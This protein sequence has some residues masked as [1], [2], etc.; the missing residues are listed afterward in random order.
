MIRRLLFIGAACFFT[1]FSNAQETDSTE[2]VETET[3]VEDN[4]VEQ[5]FQSTRIVSGHSVECLRKGVLEFRVEHRFGD[6][7]GTNGGVQNWF[8][9]DNSSDIRLAFEY[10]ITNNLMIGVGRSKGNGTPYRSLI[11][12]FG[13]YRILQQ[14]KKGMPISLAV[15]GSMFYTY[16]KALP[17]IYAVGHFP[18]QEYRFSYSAQ[19]NIARKFGDLVSLAVMP[20]VVHRNYV[21]ADDQNTLFS[22]GGAMRWSLTK[23]L[24]IMVEYYQVFQN[25]GMR[26]TNFNSLGFAVEWLTFGHNFTIYLTNA[27]GF[28]ETQF[29]TNTYDN[30]LK[31]QFRIGFCIGRKFEFGQ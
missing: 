4:L 26:K 9:F 12:G 5:T 14:K 10:G 16:M 8:G 11:D 2:A 28:G 20:T 1:H 30:W 15:T 7:A 19:L 18:K 17:D 25:K 22:L 31:G 29:I 3:E 27:R 13:K 24:G 23:R 6:L 21:A